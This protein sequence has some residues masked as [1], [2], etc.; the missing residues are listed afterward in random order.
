MPKKTIRSR[1]QRR[2]LDWLLDGGGTVS[3]ASEA[4]G[5]AMPHA[6]L[7]MR[8]LRELGEVQRDDSASIRGAIH[9]L[10]PKGADHLLTDLVE[11]VRQQASNIPDGMN[12]VVLSNDRSSIVLGVLSEPSSRLISLPRRSELLEQDIEFSSSGKGGGLWAV[13]RGSSIPWYSLS[14]LE[15]STAPNVPVEGT[16]TAFATQSDRIGILRLRLLDS[17]VTWGVANGTWIRL[18]SQDSEGP[19]Q[20]QLGEHAIGP[21]VG[22]SFVVRPEHGLYAHLPSSVDRNLLVSSLG[23]HAQLMTESLSFSSHRSLPIDILGPWM[24]KRH[25]RLSAAK[26]KTRLRSLTRWLLSGRGKQPHLNLRRAL[27]ADFGE[28]TWKEHSNAIDVVLLEGISQHGATCIVEWMLESTSF[29]MVVEWPWAELDDAALMERLLASG[30]CRVLIT[31]RGEAKEFSGKTALVLPTD[32]LATISYRP[33]ESYDFRVQLKRTTS[34]SEPESTR[35]GIPANADELLN[36]F[37]SGGMD[38]SKLSS[39][40]TELISS[41]QHIRKAMRMFP[42]GDSD[43]ANSVEREEPL[44]AWIASPE[45]ERPSRWRRIANAI[46]NGWVDLVSV[47]DLDTISLVQAMTQTDTAWREQAVRQVINSVDSD[48]SLLVDIVSLLDVDAYKAMAAHVLLLL[49]RTHRRELDTILPKAATTWLDAPFNEEQV[50]SAL[51]DATT[52]SFE[53]NDELLQ[54]F[55]RGSQVHPRGS[56]LRTWSQAIDLL[57]K[58]APISLDVMRTCINILPE[59]WW[60]T[61]ALDWLDAQLSTAGGREWLAHHPKNWPGLIFRPKGEKLGLPGHPRQHPGYVEYPN[62]K[63]NLLMVPEG[64]GT[65]ALMDVHDMVQRLENDGAVHN[66]RIHPLVGW[67]ACDVEKWPDFSMEELLNGHHEI[68]K[69]LIGR[70]MLQRM[71]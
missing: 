2:I 66:G 44:A 28:R 3:Q 33:Q 12:A 5:I 60:S 64:P 62:L 29:D 21:V 40:N 51:F 69:L 34:R 46:P 22:T 38:E 70:A 55:L 41:R 65:A 13:Q 25:P 57:E 36:W 4:L 43:F 24:R 27:L 59:H 61:W 37:H 16:L 54:R 45:S 20:L 17:S 58:G 52:Y 48:S 18:D 56:I 23:N 30:R 53:T 42:R 11:R 8:Q 32:Q 1:Y 26:R 49:G 6:S 50:L 9:R 7:A 14:S 39:Q 15:P 71:L 67:L 68:A 31:S 63:L 47:S 35:E 10:T 19:S